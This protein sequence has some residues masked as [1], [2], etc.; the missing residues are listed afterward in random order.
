MTNP[1]SATSKCILW[2]ALGLFVIACIISACSQVTNL[3]L[4]SPV[5]TLASPFTLPSPPPSPLYPYGPPIKWSYFQLWF[6]GQHEES[7]REFIR[8][9]SSDALPD[10]SSSNGS[11]WLV[12][13]AQDEHLSVELMSQLQVLGADTRPEVRREVADSVEVM[14]YYAPG[15][16][17][18][19]SVT[20]LTQMMCRESDSGLRLNLLNHISSFSDVTAE[21]TRSVV[22]CTTPN[23]TDINYAEA[24]GRFD[25]LDDATS[26]VVCQTWLATSDL[27]RLGNEKLYRRCMT[28]Q[29]AVAALLRLLDRNA[30]V[31]PDSIDRIVKVMAAD[32]RFTY[33]LIETILARWPGEQSWYDRTVIAT[34]AQLGNRASTPTADRMA[35]ALLA[36]S[37]SVNQDAL[38][39]LDNLQLSPAVQQEVLDFL[40]RA[41]E[42]GKA[43][44]SS[45]ASGWYATFSDKMDEATRSQA[46]DT[47]LNMW[48]NPDALDPFYPSAL[49]AVNRLAPLVGN[50]AVQ[51]SISASLEI[52]YNSNLYPL[53]RMRVIDNLPNLIPH[54]DVTTTVQVADTLLNL[55]TTG[56]DDSVRGS[57]AQALATMAASLEPDRQ[58][59][60]AQAIA[61]A[62]REGPR[63][64]SADTADC[65]LH[66][67]SLSGLRTLAASHTTSQSVRQFAVAALVEALAESPSPQN[68]LTHF[69]AARGLGEASRLLDES[70]AITAVQRLI[71]MAG[72]ELSD[73]TYVAEAAAARIEAALVLDRGQSLDT[74]LAR[75]HGMAS[76]P[77]INRDG[78]ALF[79][80]AVCDPVRRS[81]IEQALHNI[82]LS[83]PSSAIAA[84]QVLAMIDSLEPSAEKEGRPR[85]LDPIRP[86]SPMFSVAGDAWGDDQLLPPFCSH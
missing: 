64:H 62:F 74:L 8:L 44:E 77:E 10:L 27:Y 2:A 22:S 1:C 5:S 34:L 4:L 75:F 36:F 3:S 16:L 71:A 70:T 14:G 39:V 37:P 11:A 31:S 54:A 13:V 23:L 18:D 20:L 56:G 52:I 12:W 61:A 47:S 35:R 53:P 82:Q 66:I 59:R 86:I 49:S 58:M 42:S 80:I 6:E 50:V 43:D 40:R 26:R 65:T 63:W 76:E 45:R 84:G 24:L 85:I 55:F 19:A 15:S 72:N 17:R 7:V 48:R 21:Q 25:H 33:A 73:A 32:G 46:F 60:I 69:I 57:L 81:T 41:A 51:R 29:Q 83:A 67:N 38:N 30:N 79:L 28:E 78:V 68:C 9:L